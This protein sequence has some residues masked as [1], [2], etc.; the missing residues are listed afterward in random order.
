[1]M[2][3]PRPWITALEPYVPGTPADD[4]TGALASN[5]SSLPPSPNVR[6]AVEAALATAN[7]YPDPLA[8]DL[9]LRLANGF[10]AD[11]SQ[12]LVGN[13]SDELIYLLVTAYAAAGGA[14][15]IAD[16]P[17]RLHEVAARALGASVCRVPLR[18]WTHDL[19]AL[20]EQDVDLCFVCNPHNPS[21]TT[22]PRT[23][24]EAM[25]DD[26]RS[27]L[28]V[29]DEAYVEFA[30]DP[31]EVSALPLAV[32]G[33]LVVLRTF[34]KIHGLAGLRL[35]YM[36]GPVGVI[37]T[38]RRIR[39]PFSVNALAQA[40]AAAAVGDGARVE[41]VRAHTSSARARVRDLFGAHGYETV[42]SQANFVLVLCPGDERAL[43]DAL[44]AGGVRV[45]PGSALGA[46]GTVRVTVPSDD[47]LR[48]LGESLARYRP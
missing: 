16:P 29:V 44:S 37:D 6:G 18:R 1:M 32:A 38:L 45:R 17:Y 20:A 36:V 48:L 47:G 25:L 4:P 31:R 14:V 40:A 19:P 21:G 13:G 41:A 8:D 28:V 30:D 12:I 10:E 26:S 35:G 46:P 42:P 9:R 3:R 27:G 22:L 7:R 11:P 15:A 2:L 23:A 33:R 39:P 43:V 5:E 34:S 24:I